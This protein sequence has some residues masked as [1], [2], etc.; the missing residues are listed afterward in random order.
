MPPVT[1]IPS[2]STTGP[3]EVLP[4]SSTARLTAAS[5]AQAGTASGF[6]LHCLRRG[7]A[8]KALGLLL[9]L[10]PAGLGCRRHPAEPT[11]GAAP[12]SDAAQ[13]VPKPLISE[14][15]YDDDV[16]EAVF[17]YQFIHDSSDLQG[18][19]R[20]FFLSVYDRDPSN[21]LMD[22][23]QGHQPPVKRVSDCEVSTK[24]RG[25]GA[26]HVVDRSTREPGLIYRVERIMWTSHTEAQVT[27]GYYAGGRAASEH[28]YH[29]VRDREEWVVK[30]D[31]LQSRSTYIPSP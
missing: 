28:L 10:L 29:V 19:A 6:R 1:A 31:T 7:T 11:A 27:G 2:I 17:R 18:R 14:S 15:V 8:L 12:T 30:K 26:I 4:G 16:L 9:L 5:L 3:S 13:P 24:A 20:V 25:S 22:R 21:N 23:F